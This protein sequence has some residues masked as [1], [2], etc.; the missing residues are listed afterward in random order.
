MVPDHKLGGKTVPGFTVPGVAIAALVG[1][2]CA[3]IDPAPAGCL[4]A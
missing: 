3:T 2:Q 4:G 1:A